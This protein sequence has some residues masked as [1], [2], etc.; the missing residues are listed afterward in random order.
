MLLLRCG[1]TVLYSALRVRARASNKGRYYG[2]S[3]HWA[4]KAMV[5]KNRLQ[6]M[7]SIVAF[8]FLP[9]G[10]HRICLPL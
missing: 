2:M 5:G 9:R 6:V 10:S 1:A 7:R 8:F 4:T 3:M